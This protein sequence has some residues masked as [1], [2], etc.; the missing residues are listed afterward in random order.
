MKNQTLFFWIKTITCFLLAW[1]TAISQP[2]QFCNDTSFRFRYASSNNIHFR[3][4]INLSDFG[5]LAVGGTSQAFENKVHGLV[6]KFD[7]LGGRLWS[8]KIFISGSE[9]MLLR[10]V[11]ELKSGDYLIGAELVSDTTKCYL[12]RLDAGGNVKWQKTYL[13][14]GSFDYQDAINLYA[15]EEGMNTDLYLAFRG[16]HS[17]LTT[18]NADSS[19]NLIIKLDSA[20]N[21]IWSKGFSVAG[22]S[23]TYPYT[24]PI[25]LYNQ[26][27]KLLVI[28]QLIDTSPLCPAQNYTFSGTT[29]FAMALD[30]STGT[31]QTMKSYC[32]H[33]MPTN[34]TTAGYVKRQFGSTRL[35]NNRFA[36]FGKF[37]S[38][39]SSSYLFN[40]VFDTSLSLLRPSLFQIPKGANSSQIVVQRN[41]DINLF[42][43]GYP[44][45]QYWAKLDSSGAIK[46]QRR[47]LLP[48]VTSLTSSTYDFKPPYY[49][50]YT[51]N[52]QA[53]SKWYVEYSQ[54]QD[55]DPALDACMG[56]DTTFVT[57]LPFN[58]T[59][60][61]FSWRSVITNPV[62]SDTINYAVI[63]APLQ[64]EVVCTTISQCDSLHIAG[65]D[66]LCASN[67]FISFTGFKNP[68]CRKRVLW[69]LNTAL[70]DSTYQPNDST[71]NIRFKPLYSAAPQTVQLFASAANCTVAND[72]ASVVIMPSL[73]SLP[74]DTLV[75]GA[76]NLR[77]TPG[78]WGKK[79][80]WQDGSTDS[81]FI[82]TDTGRYVVSVQ[83]FCGTAFTDT[84]NITKTFFSV[85]A[86]KTICKND[87]VKLHATPGFTTYRWQQE[88]S[89]VASS[90]SVLNTSPAVSTQ[91]IVSVQTTGGCTLSDTVNVIV[92]QP[93]SINLGSDTTFC[94]GDSVRLQAPSSFA[95][96]LWNTNETASFITV[97]NSGIYWVTAKDGNDC[98]SLDSLTVFPLYPKPVVRLYPREVVC[99][100]Q[101]D[102]LR[103][104]DFSRYRWSDGST[105]AFLP[106]VAPGNYWLRITDA[107]GCTASDTSVVTK[108]AMPPKTFLPKDTI[109]CAREG[110]QL[111]PT[112]SFNRYLW[113]NGATSSFIE[114]NTTGLYSLRVSDNNNCIGI[115]TIAVTLK[116]CPNKI[117]F[118]S[119]FTPNGDGRNDVFKPFVEGRLLSYSFTVYNRWGGVVFSTTDYK[120]G[121]NGLLQDLPQST[122]SFV[123]L[124]R[125]QFVSEEAK[126]AKGV[127]TLIR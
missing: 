32:Y 55:N 73:N 86:D 124:C 37:Y 14:N 12:A 35:A 106:I 98:T 82:A 19:Y 97:K 54:L 102:T 59:P 18:P 25:G 84:I 90:D 105:N 96:Y 69:E 26:N 92:L 87:T 38:T 70:I 40:A 66:T 45:N 63:D 28:G 22:S 78:R 1:Q 5:S 75:C 125:Y 62:I 33:E 31:V 67:N 41:G 6:V 34:Q 121:W 2:I 17:D 116:D 91:Y 58:V 60:S 108:L 104:G 71:F 101:S 47:I 24:N 53:N 93:Q 50:T 118:P 36:L 13:T 114:V 7:A 115:D 76:V 52:Y 79:Y 126:V 51:S 89:S 16:T 107:N 21:L 110:V 127:V 3:Q 85:G 111:M 122:G 29:F 39:S 83:T 113:S 103:A 72:T 10:E 23:L 9:S 57:T 117:F 65:P 42:F 77:L 95:S 48:P 123:W 88:G 81:V 49:T 109:V 80:L 120:K 30:E 20:G 44:A 11:H 94:E 68:D 100:G 4:H 64:Q 112:Q 61:N 74:P 27:G 43:R 8:K 46:R 119:A 15:L 99:L 56:I